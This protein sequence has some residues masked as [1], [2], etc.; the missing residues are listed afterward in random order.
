MMTGRFSVGV[1]GVIRSCH[2]D[3]GNANG[4]AEQ[5]GGIGE[6]TCS[7]CRPA[8]ADVGA[9][10]EHQLRLSA[11]RARSKQPKRRP[12]IVRNL[13]DQRDFSC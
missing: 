11:V 2:W 13:D 4:I 3:A 9:S 10:V 7:A 12:N 1:A 5:G 8:R 6:T